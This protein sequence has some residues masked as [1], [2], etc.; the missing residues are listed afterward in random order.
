MFGD[1]FGNVPP[2]D[3]N[4]PET[5]YGAFLWEGEDY[6]FFT[7]QNEARHF[8]SRIFKYCKRPPKLELAENGRWLLSWAW[9][10]KP[11]CPE[12]TESSERWDKKW[13]LQRN[14]FI[15]ASIIKGEDP[16]YLAAQY[17]GFDEI[18]YDGISIKETY[19]TF[20]E[21][22]K[23]ARKKAASLEKSVTVKRSKEGS[24]WILLYNDPAYDYWI[25]TKGANDYPDNDNADYDDDET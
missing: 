6:R 7:N 11:D 13:E 21:A 16:V 1:N 22:A 3:P 5:E 15:Q 18:V 24:E 20:E 14:E 9:K 12:Y 2:E 23:A 19:V 4:D 10:E 17:G 25:R 8:T